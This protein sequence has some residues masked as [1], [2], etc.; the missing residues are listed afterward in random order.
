M[1]FEVKPLSANG[2]VI[3]TSHD[4]PE[5]SSANRVIFG[6]CHQV[7]SYQKKTSPALPLGMSICRIRRRERMKSAN[8][9]RVRDGQQ[10]R[11]YQ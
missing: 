11:F 10:G 2:C 5:I 1:A 6:Q 9:S 8:Q 4:V 3:R 7:Y